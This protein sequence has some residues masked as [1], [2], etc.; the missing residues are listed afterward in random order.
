MPA[1]GVEVGCNEW[2]I[3]NSVSEGFNDDSPLTGLGDPKLVEVG[4]NEWSIGNSGPEAFDDDSPL[5]DPK[6]VEVD[7]NE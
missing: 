1:N 2:S 6:L 7:S 3:G 4:Y 5:T